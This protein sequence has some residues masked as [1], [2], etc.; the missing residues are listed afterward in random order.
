MSGRLR[1]LGETTCAIKKSSSRARCE[2]AVLHLIVVVLSDLTEQR[3]AGG[4]DG[5][6]ERVQRLVLEY[7]LADDRGLPLNPAL[8]L[9]EDLGVESLSL[10]SLIVR[11]GDMLG[12]DVAERG[13]D[14]AGLRTL[15]D[16]IALARVLE[17]DPMA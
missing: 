15:G 7:A 2:T 10:V 12:A 13:V 11:L 8:T 5:L 1:I 17:I 9:R 4:L 6:E 3:T 14:L 16:L